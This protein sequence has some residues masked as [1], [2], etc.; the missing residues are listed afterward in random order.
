MKSKTDCNPAKKS[1]FT[2]LFPGPRHDISWGVKHLESC[3]VPGGQELS[4][5]GWKG[6]VSEHGGEQE[7]FDELL[8][9]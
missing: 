7:W 6:D 9:M 3:A 4:Q 1:L 2:N 8:K 5:A